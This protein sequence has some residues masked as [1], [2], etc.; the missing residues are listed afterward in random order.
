MSSI[1]ILRDN[2]FQWSVTVPPVYLQNV[3]VSEEK[4]ESEE[5]AQAEDEHTEHPGEV[6]RLYQEVTQESGGG[7]TSLL[8]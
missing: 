4:V 1:P 7:G 3:A 5:E 6:L 2:V 8:D